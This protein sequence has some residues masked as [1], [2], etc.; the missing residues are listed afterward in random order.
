MATVCKISIFI[1]LYLVLSCA[2]PEDDILLTFKNSIN[3]PSSFLRD[4]SNTTSL[5]HCNWTGVTCLP[6]PTLSISSLNLESLNLSGEI[7]PS[8]CQL[9]NLTHLNLAHNFFDQPIPSYLSQCGS[10]ENLNL[11]SN[12]I[13]GKIP[14]QIFHLAGSLKFLDLGKNR[15][16]GEIPE[17]IGLLKKLR[18]LNLCGNLFSGNIPRVFGNLTELEILDLSQNLFLVSEVPGEI[19]KLSKLEKLFLQNSGLYG[20]IVPNFFEGLESMAILDLSQNN[21][22][23]KIPEIGVKSLPNLVSFDVSQNKLSGP[24]PVAICKGNKGLLHNLAL[25][26]NLLNGSISNDSIDECVNLERFQVQNNGFTGNFPQWLWSLP[27]IKIIRAENNHFSGDIPDSISKA[28]HLEHV[29]IDNNSFTSKIPDGLGKITS[30]YRFSASM[31]GLYGELPLN[32]CDSEV[33]SIINLSHN[34]LSGGIPEIKNC[35]KLVSLSLS[36]N[37]FSGE[38]P[39]SLGKLPVLTYLDLSVNN[40]TGSIPEEL[41][42]LKLALFNVSFNRLSGKVPLS[43]ISGPPVSSLKGN[44]GLCGPGLPDSGFNGAHIIHRHGKMSRLAFTLVSIVLAVVIIMFLGLY[45]IRCSQK[46]NSQNGIWKSVFFYPLRVTEHDLAMSMDEKAARGNS[47]GTFG[48]TYIVKL[49]SGETV[50][51]KKLVNFGN[52]SLRAEVKTLAKIRHR[53]ITK[54]LGFCQSSDS[55]FLIY[56]CMANGSLGDIIG[57]SNFELPWRVR[58]RVALGAAQGLAYI[59]KDYSPHLL[60]RNIKSQNI[61]LDAD[62]EPKLTDF[63]LDRVVGETEFQSSIASKA[64]TSCYLAPEFGYTKKATEQMDTY[65]FGVVLLELVTGRRTDQMWGESLDVVKWV[66]RKIN[67]TDGAV[68]LLDPKISDPSQRQQM[69]EALEIALCCVAVIPEKRPSMADVVRALR[70]LSLK[71]ENTNLE[72]SD[73]AIHTSAPP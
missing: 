5:H 60:H 29:E 3:D 48:R 2:S 31:N 63:A 4:W 25:D 17:I 72:M 28:S 67:I 73:C 8:I 33:M 35:M 13:P 70:S 10:L 54:I 14:D 15:L 47:C 56:E 52:Q 11:S 44:P 21:L 38:I 61:L 53:N 20:E 68:Q 50:A 18:V 40:L 59:H 27:K 19:G 42:N 7:S 58:L 71:D 22:I 23:G 32:F 9:R 64:A 39:T 62:F 30:L 34:Y 51:V 43:L 55:I 41:Q 24:F 16:E 37:R 12:L 66:R 65:S 69:V 1:S 46:N 45:T 36:H 6:Q 49:P 26:T 57:K